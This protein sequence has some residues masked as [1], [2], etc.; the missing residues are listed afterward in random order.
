MTGRSLRGPRLAAR[1]KMFIFGKNFCNAEI[2]SQK[3]H[4]A[5]FSFPIKN[6][7]EIQ[8]FQK[9]IFDRV[10]F[11]N[12]FSESPKKSKELRTFAQSP[13]SKRTLRKSGKNEK[14]F[15][16]VEKDFG[17]VESYS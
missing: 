16:P 11:E 5:S 9:V 1:S 17:P 4:F 13:F 8:A 12:V 6:Y 3:A 14:D 2:Y 15:G 10:P 7:L